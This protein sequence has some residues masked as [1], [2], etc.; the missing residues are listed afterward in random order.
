MFG[1]LRKYDVVHVL[2]FFTLQVMLFETYAL[3]AYIF[4]GF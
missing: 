4:S 2:F 1:F 3:M